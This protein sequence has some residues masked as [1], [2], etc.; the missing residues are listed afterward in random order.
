M[1][2]DMNEVIT[3]EYC[4]TKHPRGRFCQDRADYW[5]GTPMALGDNPEPS[6]RSG[7]CSMCGGDHARG[8][9]CRSTQA[10]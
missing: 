4:K 8:Q 7:G 2:L 6:R 10:S 9:R 3:C 1:A 5:R